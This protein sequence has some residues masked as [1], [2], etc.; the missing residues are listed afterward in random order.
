MLL[1]C[2]ELLGNKRLQAPEI[3][4]HQLHQLA[5][6]MGWPKQDLPKR[7]KQHAEQVRRFH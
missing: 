7:C 6:D 1:V 2:T 3:E 4:L 5:Q